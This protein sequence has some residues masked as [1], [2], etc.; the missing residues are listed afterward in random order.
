MAAKKKQSAARRSTTAKA[1]G[2]KAQRRPA[3]KKSA[4]RKPKPK[5]KRAVVRK[6]PAPPARVAARKAVPARVPPPALAE[7]D[8]RI[9]IVQR[10]L[11]ELSE[12]AS[13]SSG[14]ATEELLSD[15]IAGQ[16]AEL[17]RLRQERDA[18][19]TVGRSSAS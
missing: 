1:K 12:Q 11:R 9:A 18:L 13:A 3:A 7:I 19:E 5:Q 6:K 4:A 14:S 17:R 8:Q 2:K 10:N 15:R 16:E